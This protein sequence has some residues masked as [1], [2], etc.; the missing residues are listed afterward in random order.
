MKTII[1]I[2][3]TALV[4][5]MLYAV[6]ATSSTTARKTIRIGDYVTVP[7]LDLGCATFRKD[8]NKTEPGPGMYC[9]RESSAEGEDSAA[10]Y[11]TRYRIIIWNTSGYRSYRVN[12]KP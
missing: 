8:P 5:T 2:V 9:S 6:P 11:I 4:C 7:A 12:R 1:T 10:V 3:A